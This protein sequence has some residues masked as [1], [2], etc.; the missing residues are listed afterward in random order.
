M[1]GIGTLLFGIGT[2]LFGIDTLLFGIREVCHT[3]DNYFSP[4]LAVICDLV[5]A[6]D[7]TGERGKGVRGANICRPEPIGEIHH[8]SVCRPEPVG[9]IHRSDTIE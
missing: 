9:E 6:V 1:F 2:P 4:V 7:G 5:R 8:R 3:A